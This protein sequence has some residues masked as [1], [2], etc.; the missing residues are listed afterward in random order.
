M[1]VL[2]L[3]RCGPAARPLLGLGFH[4]AQQRLLGGAG[5]QRTQA[6]VDGGP[7]GG[8]PL[9]GGAG[10]VGPAGPLQASTHKR[11]LLRGCP[12]APRLGWFFAS[13][14]HS[15]FSFV[16]PYYTTDLHKGEVSFHLGHHNRR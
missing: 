3:V 10:L 11:S 14:R 12:P 9:Q 8:E 6:F 13:L 15:F 2:A 16:R 5:R 7:Q 1:P 4:P